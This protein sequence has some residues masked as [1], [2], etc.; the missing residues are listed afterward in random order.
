MSVLLNTNAGVGS[1]RSLLVETRIATDD[2]SPASNSEVLLMA[3]GNQLLSP[4]NSLTK[5]RQEC[6][7]Y[8]LLRCGSAFRWSLLA[9]ALIETIHA[10][11]RV[12]QLLLAREKRMASRADFD[13]QVALL[14]GA[15]LKRF[16]AGARN[17]NLGIVWMNLWF[18]CS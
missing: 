18:H 11:R 1:G 9:V 5:D 12:N 14:G 16:A 8:Y 2:Y 15:S 10:S 7:S 6:L 4:S 17:S 13:V 3:S